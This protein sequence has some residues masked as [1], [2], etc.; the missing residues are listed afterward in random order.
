MRLFNSGKY[1]CCC[2]TLVIHNLSQISHLNNFKSIQHD[3]ARDE[4]DFMINL[5]TFKPYEMIEKQLKL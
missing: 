1:F 2:F 3:M 5:R 4:G